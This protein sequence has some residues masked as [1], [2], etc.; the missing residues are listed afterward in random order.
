MSSRSRLPAL[1]A[2]QRQLQLAVCAVA[3]VGIGSAWG[4]AEHLVRSERA[5]AIEAAVAQ[6]VLRSVAL[7][8]YVRRTLQSADL[9]MQDAV[10]SWRHDNFFRV[11]PATGIAH[12]VAPSENARFWTGMSIADADGRL[13]ASTVPGLRG[14]RNV[15]A[16]PIF[17]AH[18]EG[19]LEVHVSVPRRSRY[20]QYLDGEH[21]LVTRRIVG[22]D[23]R[24]AGVVATNLAP[25][26]LTRLYSDVD[27]GAADMISVI[28]LDGITRAR[29]T[30]Q[31]FSA[32]EDL[33]GKQVMLEQ[34]ADP[35]ASFRAPSALD[36][37]IRYFN[38]RRLPEFGL[39]VTSGVLE[40]RMLAPVEAR[41]GLYRTIAALF[42]L[43]A[44]GAAA[45][46]L[47]VMHRRRRL[48][49]EMSEA[50]RRLVEAQ[51]L[52]RIGDWRLDLR[53]GRS[54]WSD[55][56][57]EMYG[58]SRE[59][60]APSYEAFLEMLDPDGR[61][62]V[63]AAFAR[64]RETGATQRFEYVVRGANGDRHH[65][66][67][68]AAVF[69]GGELVGIYGTDRDVTAERELERVRAKLAHTSRVGAMN[70]MA[71]TLAHEINQPLA[72]ARNYLAGSRR[73]ARRGDLERVEEGLGRAED[74]IRFAG[75]VIRRI[76]AMVQDQS[77]SPATVGLAE[78]WGDAVALV[79]AADRQKDG[80]VA[81]A[82]DVAAD[83]VYA[84]RVQVQQVFVNLLRN[85]FAATAGRP[86][87][88]IA[89]SSR[90]AEGGFVRVTVSDNGPG[91]PDGLD[92]FAA[93]ASASEEGLG[94]G[95]SISRTIIEAHGGRIWADREGG[96]T[97]VHFT[98]PERAPAA[99][100]A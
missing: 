29:R 67:Q 6:N 27:T 74:Q 34:L 28:G 33:R 65:E 2:R 49:L 98:L 75:E 93:F 45:F 11:D 48:V 58:R 41:A 51:R 7:E 24:F 90:P 87:R 95:L 15:A 89:V 94:L 23:G 25:R 52:G 88:R 17:R 36:G 46:F 70:A 96:L 18:A 79:R 76:R 61:A 69:E 84:D 73:L 50:N 31:A 40:A 64:L 77:R 20:P 1:F 22:P 47:R 80:A 56:L 16:D 82:F 53:T 43:F 97:C 30:G 42:T 81:V 26:E 99:A 68:A 59:E 66:A 12:I 72:A 19:R 100:A 38:H 14:H 37:R 5:A 60:G 55:A 4:V 63:E 44:L 13:V 92:P 71:S 32:G 39:F 91:F 9:A 86:G 8:Q 10:R 78:V 62:A 54:S 3:A 35:N 83:R 85:A 57:L 21:L